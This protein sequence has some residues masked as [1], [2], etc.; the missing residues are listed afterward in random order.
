MASLVKKPFSIFRI[1]K[2]EY[3]SDKTG[4]GSFL[5]GGR[6]NPKG[7]RVIYTSESRSL[8]LCEL[9]ANIGTTTQKPSLYLVEI[10]VPKGVSISEVSK[11]ELTPDWKKPFSSNCVT[12]G[13]YWLTTAE[14]CILKV[15]SAVV[16]EEYNYV[17]NPLHPD[18]KKLAFHK[19]EK[20]SIDTR[21]FG[22]LSIEDK[23]IASIISKRSNKKDFTE[24]D[25]DE[26]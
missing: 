2:K 11:K 26:I 18:F 5:Y 8:A 6:W 24:A 1:A 22:N 4:Q 25:I 12:I 23:K 21:F 20:H 13:L 3:V 19:Q 14:T 15:P 9:L 17:L 10:C 16:E 7:Y